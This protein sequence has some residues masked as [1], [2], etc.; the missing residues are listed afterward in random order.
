MN[1]CHVEGEY[2]LWVRH[3]LYDALEVLSQEC[4]DLILDALDAIIRACVRLL[5]FQV[6][7]DESLRV[8]CL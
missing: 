3:C 6:N 5:E 2:L 4:L 7:L 1:H 8:V